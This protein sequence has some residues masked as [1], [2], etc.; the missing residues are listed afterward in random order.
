MDAFN[1]GYDA[2]LVYDATASGIKIHYDSTLGRNRDYY[3]KV[4]DLDNLKIM[5]ETLEQI[6]DGHKIR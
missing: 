1:L 6:N 4:V 3:G 5:I 2:V